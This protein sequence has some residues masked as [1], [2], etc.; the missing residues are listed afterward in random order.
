MEW[1]K[2]TQVAVGVAGDEILGG[3]GDVLSDGNKSWMFVGNV[4]FYAS[5]SKDKIGHIQ[6]EDL[7]KP[8]EYVLDLITPIPETVLN[9]SIKCKIKSK[10]TTRSPSSLTS[11]VMI[12]SHEGAIV[13]QSSSTE[14]NF[15]ASCIGD[16]VI[17][18]T[19]HGQHVAGSPITL[20]VTRDNL[21]NLAQLGL[22]PT[23]AG[24]STRTK[25][26]TS[27]WSKLYFI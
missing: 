7:P 4:D 19:L 24:D 11:L 20:P 21:E 5:I 2:K 9:S 6:A 27:N 1:V 15:Q 23:A 16:Y 8:E 26:G 13:G 25:V 3:L 10:S 14:L 17:S 12:A 22:T 18:A